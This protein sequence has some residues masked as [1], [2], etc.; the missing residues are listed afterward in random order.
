MYGGKHI[1]S[2]DAIFLFASENEGGLGLVAR[3]VGFRGRPG[4]APRRHPANAA[5]NHR[6]SPHGIG[7]RPL[8][9]T[10]LKP[11]RG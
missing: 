11:F 1:A 4:E 8:G 10:E 5:G 6:R 7:R 2:G 9:R 3:G